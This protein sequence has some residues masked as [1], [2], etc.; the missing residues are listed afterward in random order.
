M[1]KTTSVLMLLFFMFGGIW[2]LHGFESGRDWGEAV[3]KL[4]KSE[5][6]AVSSHI[7]SMK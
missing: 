5:P 7:K 1:K 6:G 2:S 3:S 4:A